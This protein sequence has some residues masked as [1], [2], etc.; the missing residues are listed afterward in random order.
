MALHFEGSLTI[1]APRDKVWSFVTDP[2]AMSKCL[3]DVQSLEVLDGGKFKAVVRVGVSFIK[4]N[5]AFD[6]AMLDLDAPRHARITG[7]GGG[8]GS[9]VDVDSTIELSDG[10]GDTTSLTWK[11][12]VVVSGTIASVGARLL[13]STVEKKTAELFDCMRVQIEA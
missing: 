10:E 1:T 7:H 3:P 2:H 4:G 13:N 8:L 9:G 12:D 6:V 5:F 11:A